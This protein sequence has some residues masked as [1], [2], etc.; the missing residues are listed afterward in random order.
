MTHANAATFIDVQGVSVALDSEG[1]LVDRTQWSRSVAEA[2]AAREG[3]ELTSAHWE[4]LNVIRDFYAT[5]ELSP[6]MRPLVK[7]TALALGAEKGRSIYLM[8]LFP[9]SPA[10]VAARLAGLPKPD[11]CL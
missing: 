9:D 2:M 5:Y 6:A 3:R 11:N 8:R 1:C 4:V 7:A 10:R